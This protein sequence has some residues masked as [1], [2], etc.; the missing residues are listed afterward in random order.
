MSYQE[1]A[2]A[3][4]A[5]VKKLNDEFAAKPSDELKAKIVRETD[6][7]RYLKNAA[8]GEPMQRAKRAAT[9]AR[10]FVLGKVVP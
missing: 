5:A 6:L 3:Q 10:K 4:E 7:L 1:Q 9:R 2:A 8:K